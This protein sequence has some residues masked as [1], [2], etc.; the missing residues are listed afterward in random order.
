[1]AY[2]KRTKEQRDFDLGV[3]G[4]SFCN[5]A[6][7]EGKILRG[8]ELYEKIGFHDERHNDLLNTMKM[9]LKR[10]DTEE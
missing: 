2:D 7:L 8:K 1:M 6:M 5:R 3:K 9:W 4:W 10:M